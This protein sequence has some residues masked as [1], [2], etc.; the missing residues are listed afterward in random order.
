MKMKEPDIYDFGVSPHKP[1]NQF[2]TKDWQRFNRFNQA[3]CEY[4]SWLSKQPK[5]EPKVKRLSFWQ[6]ILKYFFNPLT[7]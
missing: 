1:F 2:T 5:D 6:R 4:E 7:Q 3:Q